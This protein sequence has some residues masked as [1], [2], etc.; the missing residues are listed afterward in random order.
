MEILGFQV[1][2]KHVG[3]EDIE[4]AGNLRHCV[5]AQVGR[6]I[7]R[8]DPPRSGVFCCRHFASPSDAM[9]GRWARRVTVRNQNHA[10]AEKEIRSMADVAQP[11]QLIYAVRRDGWLDRPCSI[12]IRLAWLAR[13]GSRD[14]R[15]A[16]SGWPCSVMQA[17]Y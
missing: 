7:E 6:R 16:Y 5:E 4:R 12:L 14:P 1:K 8:S 3:E 15:Q 17:R 11:R 2:R 13:V 10:R 9:I